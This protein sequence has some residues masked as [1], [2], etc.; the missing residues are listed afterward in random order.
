M[1]YLLK[2]TQ[3]LAKKIYRLYSEG[4]LTQYE[5]LQLLK[6]LDSTID[7]IEINSFSI[8]LPDTSVFERSLLKQTH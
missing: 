7:K 5:Y 8:H 1:S 4:N 3:K 2:D 6:P